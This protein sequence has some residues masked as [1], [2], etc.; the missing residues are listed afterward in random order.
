MFVFTLQLLVDKW[1]CILCEVFWWRANNFLL[2]LHL[3]MLVSHLVRGKNTKTTKQKHS[4]FSKHFYTTSVLG[5]KLYNP[6]NWLKKM[7]NTRENVTHSEEDTKPQG[8]KN[9][10][11]R[12]TLTPSKHLQY[13]EYMLSTYKISKSK[14]KYILVQKVPQL[15][16]LFS[17]LKNKIK[18]LSK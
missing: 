7:Q 10:F 5:Q 12:K 6:K 15:H 4:L 13:S 2:V 14:T 17:C 9:T 16:I 18:L 8:I 3:F 11:L 1:K